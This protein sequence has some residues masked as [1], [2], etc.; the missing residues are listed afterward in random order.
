MPRRY[1][2]K[3]FVRSLVARIVLRN[4]HR[5]A[6]RICGEAHRFQS[7][8]IALDHIVVFGDRHLRHLLKSYQ[9]YYNELAR[10]YHCTR[11]RR[12]RAPSGWRRARGIRT[13]AVWGAGLVKE[14]VA[15][16]ASTKVALA[17][18]QRR[19]PRRHGGVSCSPSP[20]R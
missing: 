20:T 12:F 11:T 6:E 16:C 5:A 13:N 1:M 8:G 4:R 10:T 3:L 17:P 19:V 15:L 7:A 18:S 9:K 14:F 2:N